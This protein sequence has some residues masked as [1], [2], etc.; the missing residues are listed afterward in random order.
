MFCWQEDPCYHKRNVHNYWIWQGLAIVISNHAEIRMFG[1]ICNTE[2]E[3][4]I[5]VL[6]TV[7]D[8]PKVRNPDASICRQLFTE[9]HV[10]GKI[11]TVTH[12]K[13]SLSVLSFSMNNEEAFWAFC[14]N[15]R[16]RSF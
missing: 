15:L 9:D 5:V 11:A 8:F 6:W 3:H 4:N 12:N 14:I 10:T 7:H 13:H 2:K 1:Y 16:D